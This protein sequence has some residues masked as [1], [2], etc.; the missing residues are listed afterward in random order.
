MGYII[1]LLFYYLL[2]FAGMSKLFEK[3]GQPAWAAFVPGHNLYIWTKIIGC[4]PWWVAL[5]F[6]PIVNLFYAAGML[7]ELNKSFKFY[8]ALFISVWANLQ[9]D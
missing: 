6:I 4:P 9:E 2:P 1:F 8:G 3:A 5:W 7:I